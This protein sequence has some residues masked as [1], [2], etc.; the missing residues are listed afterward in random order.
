MCVCDFCVCVYVCVCV[1]VRVRVGE[2]DADIGQH[3]L[4]GRAD[5]VVSSARLLC[6]PPASQCIGADRCTE[7][8]HCSKADGKPPG[9]D[10]QGQTVIVC[11]CVCVGTRP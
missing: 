7:D 8:S 10:S 6:T 11:V 1:R 5:G 9:R 3:S 4:S 2:Y